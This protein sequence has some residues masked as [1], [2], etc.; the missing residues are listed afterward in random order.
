MCGDAIA[1]FR[2]ALK[3]V[4][5]GLVGDV[6]KNTGLRAAAEQGAL[7]AFEHFDALKV[8]GNDVEVAAWDLTRLFVEVDGNVREAADRA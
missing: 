5:L 3:L 8:N 4:E 2:V 7:W 6:T 1:G